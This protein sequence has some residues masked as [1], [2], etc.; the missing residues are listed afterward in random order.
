MS[1]RCCRLWCWSQAELTKPAAGQFPS[2]DSQP[3]W[4]AQVKSS[5]LCFLY[6]CVACPSDILY[7][8]VLRGCPLVSVVLTASLLPFEKWST[9]SVG[10]HFQSQFILI[11]P[12]VCPRIWNK[13]TQKKLKTTH[14]KKPDAKIKLSAGYCSLNL[15]PHQTG[16]CFPC[17]VS[18]SIK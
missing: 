7:V 13:D 8:W 17:S 5:L 1:D 12:D 14:K 9:L 3:K 16:S 15:E 18:V 2:T 11:V 10:G 4:R 6:E